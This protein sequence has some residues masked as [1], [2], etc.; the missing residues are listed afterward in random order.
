M[1]TVRPMVAPHLEKGWKLIV[2]ELHPLRE[3]SKQ[4]KVSSNGWG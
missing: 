3:R 4:F 2:E 1:S